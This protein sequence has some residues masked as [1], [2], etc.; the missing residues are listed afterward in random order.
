MATILSDAVPA[1]GGTAP[2]RPQVAPARE[3]LD[4]LLDRH[5]QTLR[6]TSGRLTAGRLSGAPWNR[7]TCRCRAWSGT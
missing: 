4:G 6:R 2:M 7:P 5:R 3:M 1:H